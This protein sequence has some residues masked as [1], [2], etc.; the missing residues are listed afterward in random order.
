LC[1]NTCINFGCGSET[2]P[3]DCSPVDSNPESR[4]CLHGTKFH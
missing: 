3:F 1:E 4:Y 2:Y